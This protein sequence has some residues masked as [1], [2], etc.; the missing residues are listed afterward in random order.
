MSDKI[1]PFPNLPARKEA[2]R[3]DGLR[4]AES[5]LGNGFFSYHYSFRSI[6][7]DGQQTHVTAREQRFENGRLE[8]EEFK[9]TTG[10]DAFTNAVSQMQ[11]VMA[12]QM[13]LFFKPFFPHCQSQEKKGRIE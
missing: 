12:R 1:R 8:T 9:G 4:R 2:R 13:E 7:T 3:S 5:A 11:N 6:A 10:V